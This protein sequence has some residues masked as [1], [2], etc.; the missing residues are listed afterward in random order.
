[1]AHIKLYQVNTL[2]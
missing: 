1:M 2:L